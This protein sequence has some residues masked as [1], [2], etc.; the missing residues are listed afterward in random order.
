MREQSY[1]FLFVWRG[2]LEIPNL[3]RKIIALQEQFDV[4]AILIK[5]VDLGIPG[6]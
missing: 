5:R 4:T 1:H 2:R 3:R 6:D